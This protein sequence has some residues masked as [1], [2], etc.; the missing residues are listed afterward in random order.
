MNKWK[1]DLSFP[2]QALAFRGEEIEPPRACGVSLLLL[3]AGVKR[4][5]LQCTLWFIGVSVR[6]DTSDQE[7]LYIEYL[8]IDIQIATSRYITE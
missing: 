6:Y 8:S 1:C 7:Q 2:L 5:S 3:S 4:L